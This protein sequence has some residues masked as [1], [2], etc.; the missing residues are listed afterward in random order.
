[1]ATQAPANLRVMSQAGARL[2]SPGRC[3][4]SGASL[5]A[6]FHAHYLPLVQAI[7]AASGDYDDAADAVQEAFVQL[8]K[9]WD[10]VAHYEDP[11]AWLR[12]VAVNRAYNRRRSLARRTAAL[13]RI[14]HNPPA[15]GIPEAGPSSAMMDT[16]QALPARQRLAMA[17]YYLG[18][19]S[20]A[21]VAQARVSSPAR[22]AIEGPKRRVTMRR[23]FIILGLTVLLILTV[24]A[25]SGGSAVAQ[26]DQWKP[27]SVSFAPTSAVIGMPWPLWKATGGPGGTPFVPVRLTNYYYDGPQSSTVESLAGFLVVR[28]SGTMTFEGNRYYRFKYVNKSTLYVGSAGAHPQGH[29][30][31]WQM[32]ARGVYTF[33][34][35]T[36]NET[37]Y[38][39]G[40]GPTGSP[41]T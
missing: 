12:R 10:R 8:W 4:V 19:L 22:N 39:T 20:V 11:A 23:R 32:T 5:D 25:V 13:L 6:L 35:W 27:F 29:N 15:S 24:L 7:A 34:T 28:S 30:G 31:V 18:D 40:T 41:A 37:E 21:E 1:L 26:T 2:T 38:L 36:G 17:L 33:D 9:H 16:F 14:A 3:A